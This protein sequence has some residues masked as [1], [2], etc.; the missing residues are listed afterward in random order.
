MHFHKVHLPIIRTNRSALYY[1]L[2]SLSSYTVYIFIGFFVFL[3]NLNHLYALIITIHAKLP[4]LAVDCPNEKGV[5]VD[6]KTDELWN[7]D[8]SN[9]DDG[10]SIV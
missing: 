2:G 1:W 7:K 6:T 8:G 5:T 4:E 10:P 3:L 9:E